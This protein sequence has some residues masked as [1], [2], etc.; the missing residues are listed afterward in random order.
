MAYIDRDELQDFPFAGTFFRSTS[1][2][3]LP[4]SQQVETEVI[5]AN[6]SC[7]VQEESNF[8]ATASAKS[9]YGVYVP[10]DSDSGTIPVK[11]GDMFRGSTYGLNIYGKVIGVFASQIGTFENYTDRSGDV[12]PHHCRGYIARVEAVD[13]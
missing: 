9:V 11:A 2:P 5:V 1:D 13:V 3:T 6:V 7:D 10:F 8:R 4:P 12:V